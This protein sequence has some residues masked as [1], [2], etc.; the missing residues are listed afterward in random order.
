MYREAICSAMSQTPYRAQVKRAGGAT[1]GTSRVAGVD[2]AD[3]MNEPQ[4][5]APSPVAPPTRLRDVL[6]RI[7]PGLIIS[8]SI[9]GSGFP[10]TLGVLP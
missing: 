1:D 3:P 8:A 9:V 7:G 2:S 6:S 10:I 5:A 4:S